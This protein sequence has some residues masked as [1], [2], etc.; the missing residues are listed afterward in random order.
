MCVYV[1]VYLLYTHGINEYV[2]PNLVENSDLEKRLYCYF[3]KLSLFN[4]PVMSN[5]HVTI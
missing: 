4:K 5:L 1:Y 2:L 3:T